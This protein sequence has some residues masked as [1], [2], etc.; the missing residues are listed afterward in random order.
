MVS[1][2]DVHVTVHCDQ[3]LKINQLDAPI[4][5]IYFGMK[6]LHVLDS[7]SVQNM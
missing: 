3:F 6:L 4:S 1:L 2:F 5:Q 7:P